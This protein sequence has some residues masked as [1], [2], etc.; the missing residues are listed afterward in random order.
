MV[1][2]RHRS[3]AVW[4]PQGRT[5]RQC[6]VSVQQQGRREIIAR[7]SDVL[8]YVGCESIKLDIVTHDQSISLHHCTNT[9]GSTS[10]FS[11][12]SFRTSLV[13]PTSRPTHFSSCRSPQS[14]LLSCWPA[15][16]SLSLR[17]SPTTTALALP[18]MSSH[19]MRI[20]A[21]PNFQPIPRKGP[22]RRPQ[23]RG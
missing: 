6:F 22:N 3:E 12:H 18:T 7:V 11:I 23:S 8:E 19:A 5:G 2:V 16:P 17:L 20:P 21:T 4:P 14:S 15:Q 1:L 13:F 9:I 10:V